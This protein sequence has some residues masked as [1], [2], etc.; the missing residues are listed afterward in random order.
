MRFHTQVGKE[1]HCVTA[2]WIKAVAHWGVLN[3]KEKVSFIWCGG[4]R[5][6]NEWKQKETPDAENN[7]RHARTKDTISNFS[8]A[9]LSI[10]VRICSLFV[11]LFTKKHAALKFTIVIYYCNCCAFNRWDVIC[12]EHKCMRCYLMQQLSIKFHRMQ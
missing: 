6:K 11:L 4:A 3:F 5:H 10:Q 2:N 9:R 7:S 8:I 12:G 1:I